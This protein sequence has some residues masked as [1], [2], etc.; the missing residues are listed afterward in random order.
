MFI[1][2][3]A[4]HIVNPCRSFVSNYQTLNH[5]IEYVLHQWNNVKL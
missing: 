4:T 2:M 5:K 1:N 3:H